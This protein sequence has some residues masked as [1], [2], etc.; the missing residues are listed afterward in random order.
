MGT[1]SVEGFS[2]ECTQLERGYQSRPVAAGVPIV[3]GEA[4]PETSVALAVAGVSASSVDFLTFGP[5]TRY[6]GWCW[7]RVTS[8]SAGLVRRL[9]ASVDLYNL[10]SDR[11]EK[12]SVFRLSSRRYQF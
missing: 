5:R 9:V 12:G 10:G 11:L 3:F 2:R 1:S 4:G 7:S 8:S 6:F